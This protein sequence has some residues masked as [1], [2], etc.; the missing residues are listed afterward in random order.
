MTFLWIVVHEPHALSLR[1]PEEGSS[2][3]VVYQ[4][5]VRLPFVAQLD[6]RSALRLRASEN[7]TQVGAMVVQHAAHAPSTAHLVYALESGARLP[8]LQRFHN[9]TIANP[10]AA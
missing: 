10:K 6:D 8:S 4:C 3:K 9:L 1:E 5:R 7:A 2:D